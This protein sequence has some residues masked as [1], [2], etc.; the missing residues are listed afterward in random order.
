M[1][2][3]RK[4]KLMHNYIYEDEEIDDDEEDE[5]SKED[6]KDEEEIK[7]NIGDNNSEP[8]I[9][10]TENTKLNTSN[11]SSKPKFTEPNIEEKQIL[12]EMGF[13]SNL[14][15]TIYNNIHPIDLQEA[16][17][18][19]N[20][21]DQGRFTHSYIENE[22][23]ICS[24]CNQGRN[25]HENTALFIDNL[26]NNTNVGINTNN[27]NNPIPLNIASNANNNN[28]LNDIINN[29]TSTTIR[30]NISSSNSNRF[31]K[32]ENSYLNT[33]NK[34]SFGN[35]YSKECGICGDKMEYIDC[36]KVKIS[37][38]HNFCLDCWENYLQ[39]K[40]NNL[41]VAK[42]SCMQ[43]GCS[44]VLSKDF[45]KKILADNDALIKKY[46]KF[47]KRQNLLM[48]NKNIKFCP[49]PDCDGYAEKKDDKYV[50]CNFGHD[51]CF[52]CLKQPHRNKICDEVIDAD[53]EE[54]K[55]TKIVK[56]CPSCKIWTEKNEGCNHMTCVECK[57]QWCWLCQKEYKYGHYDYGSCKGLQFEKEQD[58]EKI[59]KMLK[60]N[61][62]LYPQ[63][64]PSA[65]IRPLIV[66]PRPRRCQCLRRFIKEFFGFFLFIFLSPYFFFFKQMDDYYYLNCV[67]GFLYMASFL[68][69]FICFELLFF[70][71]NIIIL[72]PGLLCFSSYRAFY[73]KVK[74][75]L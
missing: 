29:N 22:R 5:K 61:L 49:I 1:E 4:S 35:S 18:F 36:S 44:V 16:L 40:I 65:A 46:E 59:Q 27:N 68:P 74:N 54:W 58:E 38:G 19:L 63:R 8:L 64:P 52:N 70:V 75:V 9:T 34:N 47:L 23:F 48:S 33:I 50:T 26:N 7:L 15:N 32:L 31:N 71:V 41:N 56:R 3:E 17:D 12:Y 67:I 42:I 51:F 55:K 24:I 25:A 43:H 39:E 53:F 60:K 28:I 62:E 2:K 37:C 45:I 66:P 30:P 72:A 57:F 73:V 10:N 13:K 21:N 20:K 11:R 14:I 69:I 6:S